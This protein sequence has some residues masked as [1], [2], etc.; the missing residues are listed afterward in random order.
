MAESKGIAGEVLIFHLDI[1]VHP[2]EI[3]P[4]QGCRVQCTA[5]QNGKTKIHEMR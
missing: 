4:D 1:P 2:Y 3:T 5:G